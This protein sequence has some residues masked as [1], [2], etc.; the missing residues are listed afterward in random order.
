MNPSRVMSRRAQLLALLTLAFLSVTALWGQQ[1]PQRPRLVVVLAIDQMRYDY[2]TRFA[3]LYTGGIKRLLDGGAVFSNANYR[4]SATETGPGHAVILSGRHPSHS[5]MVANDWWDAQQKKVINVVDDPRQEPLGGDGHKASPANFIGLALGDVLKEESPQSRVVGVSGKD[6]SAIL[7][8]GR[9]GDAAYWYETAGG[10]FITSTYYMREAPAWLKTWNDRKLPDGYAGKMWNRLLPDVALYE[11]HAGPDAIEGEWD[12]EDIVF[13]HAI[14][15]RPPDS[16]FYDDFR[17]TPHFDEV[18]LSIALEAM[19][20]HALGTDEYTDILAIGFAATD[21]VGHTYGPDSQEVMDQML[22]LDGMLETLFREIDQKVG[23]SH[24]VVVL[25]ADHGSLPLVENLQSKGIAARRAAPSVLRDAVEN[26]FKNRFPGVGGLIAYFS[27]DIYL[28]EEVIARNN[29]SRTDV[30]ATAI[31]ALLSTGLVER[32]YTHF[33]LAARRDARDTYRTLFQNAFF[34]ARSPH[35]NVLL[36]KYVYLSSRP[37]GTG[38]GTAHDYDRHIPIMFMGSGIK[39]GTY[40]EPAGPEDIA[41]SL[42]HL[43]G[44]TYPREPESRLLTEM[45]AGGS[46]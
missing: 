10:K 17:R 45:F 18:T 42:A 9:R 28:D 19:S 25:S 5:G 16:L 11:K 12:R 37:G 40:A 1:R 43:L 3:P 35:L 20:A 7:M 26:A 23:L 41:P 21:I 36:K 14:R 24:T 4:H 39:P 27:G 2:L 34:P 29:L 33:D 31:R 44:L 6:R 38:H 13:P 8:A 32:V 15:G 22:R 30:E 46:R